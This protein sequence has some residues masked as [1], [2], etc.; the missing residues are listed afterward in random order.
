MKI[1]TNFSK[2]VTTPSKIVTKPSKIVTNFLIR[3]LK[4]SVRRF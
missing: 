1:V 2:I 4:N 3:F